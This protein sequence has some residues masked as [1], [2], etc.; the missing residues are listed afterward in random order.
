LLHA[1]R[2]LP[3]PLNG[4]CGQFAGYECEDLFIDTAPP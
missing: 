1:R 4:L 3:D 2:D